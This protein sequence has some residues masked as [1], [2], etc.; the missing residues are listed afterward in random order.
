MQKLE[1]ENK[2][3]RV[4][5]AR[6]RQASERLERTH[7]REM[8]KLREEWANEVRQEQIS[9]DYLRRALQEEEGKTRSLETNVTNLKRLLEDERARTESLPSVKLVAEQIVSIAQTLVD[10]TDKEIMKK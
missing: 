7:Q 10:L 5:L 4:G 8:K 6:L 9:K 1:K 2:T 3:L